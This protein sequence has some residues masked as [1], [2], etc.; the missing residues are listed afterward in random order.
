MVTAEIIW[1]SSLHHPVVKSKTPG[2]N[3]SIGSFYI[4]KRDTSVLEALLYYL[5]QLPLLRVH[6]CRFD[7]VDT[8]KAVLK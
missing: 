2:E 4:L 6:V 8:K 7:I 1:L 5:Q 3:S